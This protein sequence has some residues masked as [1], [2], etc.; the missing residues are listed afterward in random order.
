MKARFI[1]G[2]CVACAIGVSATPAFGDPEGT[3][4]AQVTVA[5]P[6]IQVSPGQLDFGTL[7]FSTDSNS[8]TAASRPVTAT[9][10]G[11]A[12]SVLARGTNATSAAGTT[13]TLEQEPSAQ[14]AAPNRYMQR[15]SNGGA[16]LA[17]SATQNTSIRA[18]AAG[19][20]GQ[21][22]AFVVMPCVGSSGAG[23]VMTFSYVFT[24][25]L[26]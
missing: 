15:V 17:L 11:A 2:M 25:V 20:A 26:A 13:W 22:E 16:S 9:N 7:G 18:L 19:E 24:A 4:S 12:G 23:Q 6:C 3:V 14:C 10:C 1:V 8:P 21:L 5:A